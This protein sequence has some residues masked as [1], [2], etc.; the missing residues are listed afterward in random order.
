MVYDSDNT[1]KVAKMAYKMGINPVSKLEDFARGDL[2]DLTDGAD[3]PSL[4]DSVED[5]LEEMDG[6]RAVVVEDELH[7]WRSDIVKA[8]IA[9]VVTRLAN[10]RLGESA[11]EML[12]ALIDGETESIVLVLE[13]MGDLNLADHDVNMLE[14]YASDTGPDHPDYEVLERSDSPPDSL[15]AIRSN[16]ATK[17]GVGERGLSVEY[18]HGGP[19]GCPLVAIILPVSDAREL[20]R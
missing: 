3:W 20:A 1:R 8:A 15:A 2:Y 7:E 5:T 18:R 19:V 4:P 10:D 16:L 12:R 13:K 14:M 11:V 6:P 9:E 17:L